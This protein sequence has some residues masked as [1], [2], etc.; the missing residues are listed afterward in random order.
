MRRRERIG[1]SQPQPHNVLN[2]NLFNDNPINWKFRDPLV[3]DLEL[4]EVSKFP[5]TVTFYQVY[6]DGLVML[7]PKR[8][9]ACHEFQGIWW[10]VKSH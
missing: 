10:L 7:C 3:I 2:Q 6:L 8:R 5:G 4:L 9:M 1:L